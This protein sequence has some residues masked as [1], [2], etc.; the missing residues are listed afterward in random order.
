MLNFERYPEVD[1]YGGSFAGGASGYPLMFENYE[2]DAQ[3]KISL[4]EKIFKTEKI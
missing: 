2:H 4:K 3:L 1:L